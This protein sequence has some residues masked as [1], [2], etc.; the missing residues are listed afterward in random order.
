MMSDMVRA[1]V[2]IS[3]R[4]QGVYFRQSTA[5][6]AQAAGV[7][8]WVRNLEDGDVEAAFEGSR[9]AVEAMLDYMA[10]GPA[11]AKVDSVRTEWEPAEGEIAFSIR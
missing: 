8:G 6:E 3:G 1:R 2:E 9:A 4:V 11:H 10:A 5:V 7:T